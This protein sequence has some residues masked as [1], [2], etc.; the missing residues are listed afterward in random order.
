[1]RAS[2][3]RARTPRMTRDR[4]VASMLLRGVLVCCL[5]VPPSAVARA[6]ERAAADSGARDTA[7]ASPAAPGSPRAALEQYLRL[8]RTGRYTEAARYL[9]VPSSAAADAGALARQLRAV[10]DRS[11]WIELDDVSGA[12]SGDTTDG[13]PRSVEE[14][15][16]IVDSSGVRVPVRLSRTSTGEVPWR[17]SRATIQRIPSWYATLPDRWMFEHLPKALLRTGPLDLLW[18]QWLAFPLLLALATI[19]GWL[20]SRLLRGS[21]LRLVSRTATTWDDL[22]LDRLG[23]PLTAALALGAFTLA[24]P[25]LSLYRPALDATL[26]GVRV[27][28]YVVLFWSLW[29]LIDV[30]RQLLGRSAWARAS[31][32]SRALLPLAGRI[33]KVAVL[34]IAAVA[35]LSMLG[36]PVAS[37]VAGLGIG[38]L[39]LAL[40]AQKTVENLFGAFSIGIDQPFREGDVVKIEEFV[41]T[42][43][44]IGLRSTRFRT[45]DRTIITIPNGKLAE[46]RLESLA[47]RDRLRLA[48]I[49]GLVHETTAE[50]LREVLGGIEHA[51]RSHP[52]IWPDDVAVRFIALGP[53]SLDVEITAWF[54][55]ADWAEFL[56]IRQ[57][58]LLQFMEIV[59]RAGTAFAHPTSTVHVGSAPP[60]SIERRLAPHGARENGVASPRDQS[61]QAGVAHHSTSGASGSPSGRET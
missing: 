54:A 18:W 3:L 39:A 8:T 24:V 35:V 22:V 9:D 14:V 40:A 7:D 49:I 13:L 10:L 23:A 20:L 30:G 34:A 43:E 25:W 58:M 16:T 17:F 46:M 57:D 61:D 31:R 12:A 56:L 44:A 33:A 26:R 29:R 52:R 11:V 4:L 1:M 48:M 42:V 32:S 27:A 5:L 37:L 21:L 36:Y 2:T 55:T 28:S 53:S 38:G 59:E 51:L 45:P 6:Q 50:Q 60:L 15:G 19:V 47:V 41:G